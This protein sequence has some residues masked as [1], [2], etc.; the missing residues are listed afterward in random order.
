MNAQTKSGF[1][2]RPR[3]AKLVVLAPMRKGRCRTTCECQ[4]ALKIK[5]GETKGRYYC[6]R[7]EEFG[8]PCASGPLPDGTCAR[9]VTKCIPVRSL[10]AKRKI[11]TLST[12]VVTIGFLLVALCGSFRWKFISPGLL[13]TPHSTTAVA[14]RVGGG[15]NCAVCHSAARGGIFTWFRSGLA[16]IPGPFQF[17]ALAATIDPGLTTI[18][19]H[20]LACH[21]GHSFHEPNVTRVHS[22]SDCHVEHQ[23]PGPMRPPTDANCLSCHGNAGV[24]Q[25]SFDLGKILPADV[26]DFR[27]EGGTGAFSHAS[28]RTR[29]YASLPQLCDGPSRVSS[30]PRPVEGPRHFKV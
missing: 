2:A 22:C 1:A 20:C 12:V 30:H 17:H 11:L 14:G 29:L 28:A 8:G 3:T 27:P 16:A 25:A 6:T 5:P 21:T 19:Q 9:P 13:S 23:G 4:P 24:M 10:R 26:F 7:T 15:L 18:D